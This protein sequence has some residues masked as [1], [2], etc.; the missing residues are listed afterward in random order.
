MKD[1]ISACAAGKVGGQIVVDLMKEEDNFGECD[2]PMA[3]IPRRG[4]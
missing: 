2:L 3:L 1:L 4:K